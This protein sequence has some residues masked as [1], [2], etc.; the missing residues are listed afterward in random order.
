MMELASSGSMNWVDEEEIDWSTVYRMAL[1][2]DT[3]AV[4]TAAQTATSAFDLILGIVVRKDKSDSLIE[5][6]Q[7]SLH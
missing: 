7:G 4:A 2:E 1:G 3:A 6:Y 5:K